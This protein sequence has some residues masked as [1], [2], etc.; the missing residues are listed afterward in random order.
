MEPR[1]RCD[2][3]SLICF[4]SFYLKSFFFFY[5]NQ[6]PHS[7]PSNDTVIIISC[8]LNPVVPSNRL[9]PA[10]PPARGGVHQGRAFVDVGP[11]DPA[12]ADHG[13]ARLAAAEHG[14]RVAPEVL[15]VLYVALGVGVLLVLAL[16]LAGCGAAARR[17]LD[18][19][20]DAQNTAPLLQEALLVA[21]ARRAVRTGAERIV[22][23][24]RGRTGVRM[25]GV[26]WGTRRRE[27]LGL[28]GRGAVA[29]AVHVLVRRHGA[30]DLHEL[31]K[32]EHTDPRQLQSGPDPQQ[33]EVGIGVEDL[34]HA[35]REKGALIRRRRGQCREVAVQQPVKR[36]DAEG[37]AYEVQEE[38]SMVVD[39]NAVVDPRAVVVML[40]HTA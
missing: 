14:R 19:G 26:Q 12:S 18:E 2:L 32:E 33:N 5:K 20:V 23:R 15:A 39:T 21:M 8:Q 3:K 4:P 7:V 30:G 35:L 9:V 29:D 22:G 6:V 25:V 28:V 13:L 27:A 37:Q 1:Y 36:Q 11:V 40:G 10:T 24:A 16:V 38:V 34:A 17:R 31:H